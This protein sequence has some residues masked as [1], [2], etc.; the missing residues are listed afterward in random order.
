MCNNR[1][2]GSSILTT[3]LVFFIIFVFIII[4]AAVITWYILWI[5]LF[6]AGAVA[7]VYALYIYI[8]E[9]I[10]TAKTLSSVTAQSPIGTFFKRWFVLVKDTSY[11]ALLENK[12]VAKNAYIKS[13]SFG[14]IS[15]RKW[16]Y[17][18]L[19]PAVF[20]FG[21]IV[22]LAII[23]LNI[24]ILG[25]AVAF[26]IMVTISALLLLL[27]ADVAYYMVQVFLRFFTEAKQ[28]LAM[29]SIGYGGLTS[30]G[31]FGKATTDYWEA[32]LSSLGDAWKGAIS[33]INVNLTMSRGLSVPSLF[34]FASPLAILPWSI[35]YSLLSTVLFAVFYVGYTIGAVVWILIRKIFNI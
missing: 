15:I 19:C 12:T 7:L 2:N 13:T 25:A 33:E 29:I 3:L 9:F 20:I 14:L 11:N 8:R 4:L 5:A 17:L 24:F 31:D 22:I 10:T 28:S 18:F 16:F 34:K 6:I 21:G 35:V 1:N 27:I 30:F 23:A 32:Y 26:A